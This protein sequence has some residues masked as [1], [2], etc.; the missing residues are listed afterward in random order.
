MKCRVS[1]FGK[2]NILL[3]V[4]RLTGSAIV[5]RIR[6]QQKETVESPKINKENYFNL[7][8]FKVRETSFVIAILTLLVLILTLFYM[9]Q[10]ND[11]SATV[12]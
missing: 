2:T 4:G 11:Y 8:L 3:R 12:G 7:W 9:K 1:R 6:K 5:A 10:Q